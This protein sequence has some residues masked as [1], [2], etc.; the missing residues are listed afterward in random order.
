MVPMFLLLLDIKTALPTALVMTTAADVYILRH[1]YRDI[2]RAGLVVTMVAAV[3]GIIAG[4]FLLSVADSETLKTALAVLVI[5][6]A[7]K[8][9][10]DKPRAPVLRAPN[11]ALAGGAGLG[12]GVIDAMLGTGGPPLIM[13][14]SWLGLTKA[15]FRATFVALALVIHVSRI[16]SYTVAGLFTREILLT[17]A[18]LRRRGVGG[19]EIA[20]AARRGLLL[21]SG[22]IT[23]EALVGILLAIPIVASG[24]GDVLALFPEPPLGAWPGLLLMLAIVA[25][26]FGNGLRGERD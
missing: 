7:T 14:F 9:L 3:M 1:H 22:L 8:M 4:T 5:A 17:G 23:G 20:S 10:F 19:K 26:M 2:H 11:R 15:A 12:A 6:F 21:A 13:Y 24:R 18:M 25:W 16:A